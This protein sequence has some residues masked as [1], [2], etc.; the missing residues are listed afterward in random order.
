MI[1]VRS[2]LSASIYFFFLYKRPMIIYR[3]LGGHVGVYFHDWSKQNDKARTAY[4]YNIIYIY[5]YVLHMIAVFTHSR[6]SP[7]VRMFRKTTHFTYIIYLLY[8]NVRAWWNE[9]FR[10]E[11]WYL[12]SPFIV[13]LNVS[14]FT[15]YTRY[16]ILH[17]YASRTPKNVNALSSILSCFEVFW[18]TL[19]SWIMIFNWL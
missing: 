2:T 19:L 6:A 14:F 13:S 1:S 18:K 3:Q 15:A 16:V 8:F 10:T 7:R 11:F 12:F 5:M 4:V 17:Y 9:D